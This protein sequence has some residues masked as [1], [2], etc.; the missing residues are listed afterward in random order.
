M[1][2]GGERSVTPVFVFL[3]LLGGFLIWFLGSFLYKP[4]GN[5]IKH[6]YDKA[7]RAIFEKDNETTKDEGETK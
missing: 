4:I 2:E 3:V 6:F 5:I 1:I 7:K